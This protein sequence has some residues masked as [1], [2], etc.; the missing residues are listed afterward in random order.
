MVNG[1]VG[2][3]THRKLNPREFRGFALVDPLAP[4]V[5]I[6]G[7]DTKAAQIF[8]LAH[9]LA[10]LWLGESALSDADLTVQPM[11][12]AERWCN[13]VAAEFLVPLEAVTEGFDDRGALTEQTRP[14]CAAVP[15]SAPSSY[16]GGFTT[17]VSWTGTATARR[18]AWNSTVFSRS[19]GSEPTVLATSTTRNQFG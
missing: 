11:V 14:P 19:S 6:N 3:N 18:I 1:V 15:G 5:F 7:A 8:S 17:P 4:L 9:E 13:Q 2:S 16:C 10:H 12:A